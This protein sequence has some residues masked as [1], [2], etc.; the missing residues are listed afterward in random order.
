MATPTF[1]LVL[2][3]TAALTNAQD[4]TDSVAIIGAGFSGLST[5]FKLAEAGYRNIVVYDSAKRVGGFVSSLH[6]QN[7]SH[8]M[9][10]YAQTPAYWKFQEAMEGIGV[11]FCTLNV[12]VVDTST[13]PP[14][15]INVLKFIADQG[16]EQVG[17]DPV[18]YA[19]RLKR[20]ITKYIALWQDLFDLPYIGDP[21]LRRTD[22]LFPLKPTDDE[23]LG[24]LSLPMKDFVALYKL[25]LLTPLFV[26]ATDSQ[27]Y[28]PFET[29]PALYYLSW[30]PPSLLTGDL[31]TIPC[32]AY[33][34]MQAIAD[35]MMEVLAGKVVFNLRSPV[36][37]VVRKSTG[38]V[39]VEESGRPVKYD[40]V[41]ISNH[42]GKRRVRPWLVRPVSSK[43]RELSRT[44]EE[45]QIFSA[46]VRAP[47]KDAVVSNGFLILDSDALAVPEPTTSFWGALNAELRD[48]PE[49]N[50][51]TGQE[52]VTRV[53][54]TYYY[55]ERA[56]GTRVRLT[57]QKQFSNLFKN[58]RKWDSATYTPLG[59]RTYDAY[60]QRWGTQ[61]VQDRLPW[62]LEDNQGD[63]NV[64]Y[65]NAASCGFESVG[66]VFD[67]A[68]NVVRD[69]FI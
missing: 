11:E 36:R 29:T 5:A 9:A 10:T 26:Q 33:P 67:C 6:Y 37:A 62:A 34:S 54:A 7:V 2:L 20:T 21:D 64:Y 35:R 38:A 23:K 4:I 57:A 42:I 31:G 44:L 16:L 13:T 28:G 15:V 48:Y 43:E 18:K 60:F 46:F 22:R 58:L 63:G 66:H 61:G 68:D 8:D 3:L 25:E 51:F 19:A 1:F 17:G 49:E 50:P 27:A 24:N 45:L 59:S 56:A 14:N 39:V 30:V 41:V 12:E 32:G 53:S 47:R 65:V 40:R 52:N 55:A 69:Y